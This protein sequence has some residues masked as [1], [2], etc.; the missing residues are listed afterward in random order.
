MTYTPSSQEEA[1]FLA[2]Y[3][4]SKYPITVV[5]VDVVAYDQATDSL[6]LIRRANYPYA[7]HFA[8][9]GGFIEPNETTEEAARRELREE[10]GILA[11]LL[12][13][14]GVGDRPDRDPRGRA[15]SIAYGTR[16]D[17]NTQTPRAGDD[18]SEVHLVRQRDV[19]KMPL[20]FDHDL[21]IH[22]AMMAWITK[23]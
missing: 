23:R 11:E 22:R 17:S 16:F 5:T 2:S 3:D 13:F 10:T 20:A 12:W 15:I 6:L 14:V 21:L 7:G 19:F 4:P 1:D 8:L 9:P 18:A